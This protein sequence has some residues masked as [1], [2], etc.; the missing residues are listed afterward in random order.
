MAKKRKLKR[1]QAKLVEGIIAG[2]T[3]AQAAKGAAV[4]LVV[5]WASAPSG[6]P[7]PSAY[8]CHATG[9]LFRCESRLAAGSG[10]LAWK[11]PN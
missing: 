4:T 6:S 5:V 1:K 9:C 7:S 2:K 11:H 3:V 10:I 8:D